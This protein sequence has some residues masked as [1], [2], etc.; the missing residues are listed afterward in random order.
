MPSKSLTTNAEHQFY[1]ELEA[2]VAASRNR[3][4]LNDPAR[5]NALI[6][7][8][9][10]IIDSCAIGGNGR[11]STREEFLMICGWAWDKAR[12]ITSAP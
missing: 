1:S 11:V 2:A 7:A 9:L 10:A 5:A 3:L 4:E 8:A 6:V 12:G